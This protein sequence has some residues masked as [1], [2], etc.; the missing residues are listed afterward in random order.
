MARD[1]IN[2]REYTDLQKQV[3]NRLA[4]I[5]QEDADAC[6]QCGGEDCVCCEIYH[7]RRKWVSSDELFWEE[8]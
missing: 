6:S 8:W 3:I 1:F 7:D 4:E 2:N 5:E